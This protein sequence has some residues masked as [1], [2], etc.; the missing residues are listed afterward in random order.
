MLVA[1][2]TGPEG[3]LADGRRLQAGGGRHPHGRWGAPTGRAL[4]R[5]RAPARSGGRGC[6][7][8]SARAC[9]SRPSPRTSASTSPG[10][11]RRDP[12]RCI[13]RVTLCA[14]PQGGG[15]LGQPGARQHLGFAQ[16]SGR[17]VWRRPDLDRAEAGPLLGAAGPGREGP[18]APD[19]PPGRPTP[20]AM[21]S[22]MP[23]PTCWAKRP[24]RRSAARSSSSSTS[25]TRPSS[26]SRTPWPTAWRSCASS[27]GPRPCRSP[28]SSACPTA[29]T[30]CAACTGSPKGETTTR[31][32]G[33]TRAAGWPPGPMIARPSR[34]WPRLCAARAR[35]RRPARSWNHW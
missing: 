34:R 5:R 12:G 35:W 27:P 29:T 31:R 24:G 28:S 19:H 21:G 20:I 30:P 23:W 17:E 3:R 25:A 8:A 10:E 16:R 6:P 14:L 9:W 4:D 11:D 33:A 26:A 15:P 22:P 2:L 7:M 18:R 32:P 13:S 1:R